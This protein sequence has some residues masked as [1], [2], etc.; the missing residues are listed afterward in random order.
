MFVYAMAKGVRLGYLDN[1]FKDVARKGFEG[2]L[3]NFIVKD[4]H[5]MIH[6]T[7]SCSG[8]GLG[9][10][11]YRDGSFEYYIKEPLRTDDLKAMGPFMQASVEIELMSK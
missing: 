5:G 8:A 3:K 7:K 9:G 6:L 4:E 1:P 11:P 10:K 2:I